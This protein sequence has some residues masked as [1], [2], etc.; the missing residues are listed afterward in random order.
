MERRLAWSALAVLLGALPLPVLA[1]TPTAS[2]APTRDPQAVARL[3]ASAAA[4]AKA[5]PADSVATGTVTLV[6]GSSTDQGTVRILT[7]GTAETAVEVQTSNTSWTV[8]YSSS[9]ASRAD[10]TT[11]KSLYLEQA[12]SSRCVYFPYP[13][14]SDL[15][16]N[17]DAAFTYVGQET[18]EQ[19]TLQHIQAWNTFNSNPALRF[20]SEFT[21]VDIWLDEVS[22]LPR[23]ISFIRRRGGGSAPRIP[24]TISYSNYRNAGGVLYPYLIEESVNGTVWAT[25]TIESVV[26]NSGLSDANFTVAAE[27]N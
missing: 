11:T 20:L 13:V 6:A 2:Q 5:S 22:G 27:A 24:V 15:L 7:R 14:I 10:G 16:T 12:A 18:S 17:P 25:I 19:G 4:M 1:Q 21:V 23:Q 26:F 3:Q 9:K 8:T